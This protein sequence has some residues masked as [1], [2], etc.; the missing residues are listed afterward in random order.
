MRSFWLTSKEHLMRMDTSIVDTD[1]LSTR[2][3]R[4][5]FLLQQ[6]YERMGRRLTELLSVHVLLCLAY[7][8]ARAYNMDSGR[9]VWWAL[10]WALPGGGLLSAVMFGLD[11]GIMCRVIEVFLKPLRGQ[12]QAASVQLQLPLPLSSCSDPWW[13]RAAVF[14]P[15]LA[16]WGLALVWGL[17]LWKG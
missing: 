5:D 2:L 14:S 10:A 3:Q 11:I 8:A 15:H 7:M 17:L 13:Y 16:P 6:T 1:P 12:L 4:L 9:V